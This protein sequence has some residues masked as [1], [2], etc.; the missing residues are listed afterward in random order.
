MGHLAT[1]GLMGRP[2][3]CS[4][5]AF[6]EAGHA[7]AALALSMHVLLIDVRSMRGDSAGYVRVNHH[8]AS[9]VA[10]WQVLLAGPI[11]ESMGTCMLSEF[12]ATEVT[13]VRDACGGEALARLRRS[14]RVL[15]LQHWHHVEA[16]AG[17]MLLGPP[18][19]H[20]ASLRQIVE[21]TEAIRAAAWESA[22]YTM[23]ARAA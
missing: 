18:I 17:H 1:C 5:T 8:R 23:T 9:D 7:V 3:G 13:E 20:A 11:A 10:W 19:V 16:I 14:T 15:L 2:C 21:R 6:H 4:G 12:Y 22:R